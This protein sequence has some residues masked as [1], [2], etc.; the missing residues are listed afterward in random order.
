MAFMCIGDSA[1][2]VGSNVNMPRDRRTFIGT[3][4]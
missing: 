3:S 4:R 1:G 2:G